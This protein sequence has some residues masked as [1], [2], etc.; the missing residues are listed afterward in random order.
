[1]NKMVLVALLAGGA[2]W[3]A[4]SGG[5]GSVMDADASDRIGTISHGESVAIE[6]YL[7]EDV[8]TVVVF[9]ADW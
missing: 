4:F 8:R 6:D 2:A 3:Y 5:K 7:Q 9:E 1:M